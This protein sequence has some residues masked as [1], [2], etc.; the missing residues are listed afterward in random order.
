MTQ[1]LEQAFREAQRLQPA[2]QDAIAQRIL[3]ELK[4]DARWNHALEQTTEAQWEK[5]AN[6]ARAEIAAGD[7]RPLEDLFS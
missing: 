7:L 2:E 3:E 5:I 4:E 6:H 1:L